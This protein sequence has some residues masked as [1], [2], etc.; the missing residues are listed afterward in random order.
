MQDEHDQRVEIEH[1]TAGRVIRMDQTIHDIWKRHFADMQDGYSDDVPMEGIGDDGPGQFF[2][3]SS[4]LD[5]RVA[6]WAIKEGI[7]HKSLDRLLAI[8]GVCML[9]VCIIPLV[10]PILRCRHHWVS[11][12]TT[13][14]PYTK[15]LM[16]C[17]REHLGLSRH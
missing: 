1:P 15:S 2:P 14:V 16:P 12:S 7:G 10:D 17:L 9:N 3:F 6:H 4:E 5:W 13:Y 8:P 11:H